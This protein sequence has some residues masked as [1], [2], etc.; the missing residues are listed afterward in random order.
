MI[1]LPGWSIYWDLPVL[2]IVVSLVYS[3]TRYDDWGAILR[4][5]FRWG[6]RM[7]TFLGG[8]GVALYFI[9]WWMDSGMGWWVL[10]IT[11]TG[12]L[13]VVMIVYAL[14]SQPETSPR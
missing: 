12:A 10:A 8:I 11:G 13:I 2:I 3:A 5:A 1:S 14:V 7:T 6:V 9:A 4:E